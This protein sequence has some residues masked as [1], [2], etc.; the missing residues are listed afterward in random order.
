[1]SVTQPK[2]FKAAGLA[3]GIKPNDV[4]DL[5]VVVADEPAVAAAMFTVNGF[6][7]APVLVS[8]EHMAAAPSAKAV[9][10]NGDVSGASRPGLL[11][12]FDQSNFA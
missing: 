7:A 11:K 5:T 4:H 3:A 10:I 8:K 9:V 6:P 12:K 1:M 2:G